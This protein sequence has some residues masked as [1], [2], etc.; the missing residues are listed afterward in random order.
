MTV[1]S[2][3]SLSLSQQKKEGRDAY[4]T[5]IPVSPLGS[6]EDWRIWN[7]GVPVLHLFILNLVLCLR[8][9]DRKERQT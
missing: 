4:I 2:S 9:K 8:N 3:V 5:G 7:R 1:T 6:D